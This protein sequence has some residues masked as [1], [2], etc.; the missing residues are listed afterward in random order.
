MSSTIS[1]GDKTNAPYRLETAPSTKYS[2]WIQGTFTVDNISVGAGNQVPIVILNRDIDIKDGI[3]YCMQTQVLTADGDLICS[4]WEKLVGTVLDSDMSV[5]VESGDSTTGWLTGNGS[6]SFT[7]NGVNY[8]VDVE[9]V[10][11][12]EF[13]NIVYTLSSSS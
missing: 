8:T 5:E 1:I 3:T 9:W 12:D 7:V 11:T 4:L 2:P 13:D 10:G 6:L